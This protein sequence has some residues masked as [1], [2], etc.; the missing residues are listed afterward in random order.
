MTFFAIEVAMRAMVL[1]FSSPSLGVGKP[2]TQAAVSVMC[3]SLARLVTDKIFKFIVNS[4]V[5]VVYMW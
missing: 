4:N 1:M 2:V 3:V 5:S